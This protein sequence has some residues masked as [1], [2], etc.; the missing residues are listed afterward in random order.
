MPNDFAAIGSALYGRLGTVQ[1]SY[2]ANGTALVTGT[3]GCYDTLA[4]QGGTPP[5]VVFQYQAGVN[6]YV[7][8]GGSGKSLDFLVKVI[9]DRYYASQQAFAIYAKVYDTLQDA[10]LSIAGSNLLRCREMRPVQLR[11]TD[12]FWHVG[13]IW[14]ID[15]WH[16]S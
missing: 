9:S 11:D 16:S 6:D 3:L 2:H 7:F 5:Y 8:G 4:P 12:G 1:Y 10:P 14:R 13:G 15:F